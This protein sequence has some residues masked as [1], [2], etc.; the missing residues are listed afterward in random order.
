MPESAASGL[1]DDLAK[2]A[3]LRADGVISDAEFD[4]LKAKLLTSLSEVPLLGPSESHS[5]PAAL[6]LDTPVRTIR[7]AASR[8]SMGGRVTVIAAAVVCL[9]WFA[10][11]SET[12]S[13]ILS[14]FGEDVSTA[15]TARRDALTDQSPYSGL[16]S[17]A[18]NVGKKFCGAVDAVGAT[19]LFGGSC[20]YSYASRYFV[21]PYRDTGYA[22]MI[23]IALLLAGGWVFI[24]FPNSGE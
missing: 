12:R 8:S 7:H 18:Y 2:F 23:V 10:L 21:P 22:A 14:A 11:G 6:I 15:L 17:V 9:G 16:D 20:S 3:K 1:A 4:A 5:P 13:N 19:G 24:P